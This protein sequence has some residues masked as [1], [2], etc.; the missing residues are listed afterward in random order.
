MHKRLLSLHIRTREMILHRLAT[1]GSDRGGSLLEYAAVIILV[2]GVAVAIMQLEVFNEI[3]TRI[4]TS[5]QEV[6]NPGE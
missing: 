2:G 3:P 4:A 5:I 1:H 6:L